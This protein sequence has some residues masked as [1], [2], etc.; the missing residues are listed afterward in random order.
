MALVATQTETFDRAAYEFVQSLLG[1]ALGNETINYKW[2]APDQALKDERAPRVDPATRR[3][4]LPAVTMHRMDL[5]FDWERTL[6]PTRAKLGYVDEALL[7]IR[8]ARQP[9]PIELTWQVDFWAEQQRQIQALWERLAIAFRG[10]Y[11]YVSVSIDE[12]WGSKY[13]PLFLDDGND[14]SDVEVGEDAVYRRFTGT[15]RSECWLYDTANYGMV[16]TV[17]DI[18]AELR[19]E[20]S[21]VLWQRLFSPARTIVAEGDGATAVYALDVVSSLP[22]GERTLVVG[23]LVGGVEQ[24]GFDNGAGL[25]TGAVTG[26]VDYTTG[27][28]TLTFPGNVDAGAEIYEEHLTE[29]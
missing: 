3:P 16:R 2:V 1:T 9:L 23:S 11:A 18:V 6:G 5:T 24:R 28:V 22:I 10:S 8:T 25:I 20:G 26:T 17:R 29:V 12:H 14:T 7:Q 19:E 13:L 27:A 15:L 4:Q 21:L